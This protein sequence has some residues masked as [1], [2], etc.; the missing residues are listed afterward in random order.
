MWNLDPNEPQV[1]KFEDLELTHFC[2]V[3][4]DHLT[5]LLEMMT[6]CRKEHGVV[7]FLDGLSD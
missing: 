5:A 7:R 6:E 1:V 3:I 4:K 2:H